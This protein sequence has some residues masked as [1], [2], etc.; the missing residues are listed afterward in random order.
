MI[1][2]RMW[3][4]LLKV[5][6]FVGVGIVLS[7]NLTGCS[8][9]SAA[10][11]AELSKT[12]TYMAVGDKPLPVVGE[13]PGSTI[14]ANN[15]ENGDD[16][17]PMHEQRD[18]T[19]TCI[20]GR[21]LD[22]EG[23]PVP[24]AKVRLAV[25][26]AKGGK[27]VTASTDRSGAFTLHSLRPGS[28]YTVIAEWKGDEGLMT[29]R[30]NAH[31]SDTD[32]EISLSP[33][34][35]GRARDTKPSKVNRVSEREAVDDEEPP[36]AAIPSVDAE[37]RSRM[38]SSR[39]SSAGSSVNEE[40]MPPAT[41]AETMVPAGSSET[42]AR[43]GTST[44]RGRKVAGSATWKGSSGNADGALQDSVDG[45]SSK[46]IPG[47]EPEASELRQDPDSQGAAQ[48]ASIHDDSPNPLPPALESVRE[49][50]SANGSRRPYEAET[51]PFAGEPPKLATK[52][53]A[54]SSQPPTSTSTRPDAASARFEA[55]T[56]EEKVPGALVVVPEAVAPVV[57]R[58]ADP[59]STSPT[60]PPSTSMSLTKNQRGDALVAAAA[61]S[62]AKRALNPSKNPVES[63]R[64]TWGEIAKTRSPMPP[65]EGEIAKAESV[66]ADLNVARRGLEVTGPFHLSRASGSKELLGSACDYDDR[67]RLLNDF[68][69]PDL[70][71]NP[72]RFK[73]LDA[74]FIL[75]DFWGTWC[76]PCLKSIPHLIELQER[77]GKKLVVLGIACEQDAPENSAKRVAET[78]RKLKVNYPVLLSRNDG[79]CP[80]QEAFHIQAFPT[81][82]LVDR[83]GRI[84]WRDQ[85]STPT[86][87]A[88][89]D[90]M[91]SVDE[92]GGVVKR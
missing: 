74:D 9:L 20:S 18:R 42:Q 62:S 55:S 82:I 61:T 56:A 54:F 24:E 91:L 80:L 7:V 90:R 87:L 33:Q 71:G 38:S 2:L 23:R 14:A 67:H 15:R 12:K 36:D 76:E 49:K 69:L 31:A 60:P 44:R 88:R 28:K 19:D 48:P 40:D 11:T 65:L 50:S 10:R 75:L 58:E 59:F 41:E 27:V 16:E 32:V 34:H 66:K 85:G 77:M 64:P 68:R 83:E 45:Q 3:P 84:L 89:L 51:D 5:G 39:R 72:M 35:E 4:S 17:A 6:L 22:A 92:R 53:P 79:S 1:T 13:E 37:P 47:T 57:T 29:G 30:S 78:A 26:G 81:M 43:V 63:R 21:V 46:S 70:S 73:D 86:T 8:S 52:A 25:G